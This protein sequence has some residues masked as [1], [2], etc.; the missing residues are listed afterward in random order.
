MKESYIE[1]LAAHS[2][3][4]SC[5]VAREGRGEALT[6]VRAGRVL[7]RERQSLRGA[8][9]VEEGGRPHPAYR[10]REIR[11]DPAL[12]QTPCMY[13]NT[14]RENRELKR[15]VELLLS[16]KITNQAP[17]AQISAWLADLPDK[18]H[19]KLSAVELVKPRTPPPT[20]PTLGGW[21]DK[22]TGERSDWKPST[23]KDYGRTADLLK[24]YFGAE[25]PI[26]R[27][28]QEQAHDWRAWLATDNGLSEATV[29]GH[30]RNVKT[31]FNAA[32]EREVL[33][34]NPFRRLAS[35]ASAAER[36]RYVTA[37]EAEQI[38][39]ACPDV[40]WQTLFGLC[41]FAGLR[42]PGETHILTWADVDWDRGRLSV[43]SPKTERFE[44]HRRRT[45]PI[46]PKLAAILQDAF[47]AAEDGQERVCGL[48][49][50][51]LRR[52]GRADR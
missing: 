49:R 47:D 19:A 8:D 30:C 20:A 28:T 11:R 22:Y 50:N 35:G 25:T 34:R 15:K 40:H 45:V 24:A 39:N 29:R 6:G 38:L 48:S 43:R 52:Q 27:I 9:A 33:P 16:A 18:M 5:G 23:R 42:C 36:G 2:G 31:I 13:G 3:P 7:S 10:Y 46:T 17:D 14:S 37:D 4:E 32:A 12:S 26:D 51:N 41:R 1:G 44:R 21:L